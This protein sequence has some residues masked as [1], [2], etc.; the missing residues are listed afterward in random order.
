MADWQPGH[1]YRILTPDGALW[2][3]TSDPD[4][5]IAESERTGLP[6]QRQWVR[7]E[8][9]WRPWGATTDA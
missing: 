5:A 1:W 9:Q 6:I 2:M 4:E 7:E 3:E 8:R